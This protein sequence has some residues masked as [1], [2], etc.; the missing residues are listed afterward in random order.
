MNTEIQ[1]ILAPIERYRPAPWDQ[2]P[3]LGLY[4][5]QVV[6]FITRVYEPLYGPQIHNYLSP[7]MINNYVKSKLIPR[8]TGKK[9]SRD[10][11]ALLMMIVAL[12]QTCSMEDIRTLLTLQ[13][14]GS[15]EQLYD[16]FCRRFSQ[17]I[18]SICGSN[19]P[20]EPPH[21]ALDLAILASGYS[22]GCSAAL[23]WPD[24]TM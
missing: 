2:I 20:V 19:A 14:G 1:D 18:R 13:E 11:I 21:T 4:M 6:T 10:Q 23:K 9:Y 3:D 12:K 16:G 15:V 22:A 24:A 5:D 7:S 8:P 17:V